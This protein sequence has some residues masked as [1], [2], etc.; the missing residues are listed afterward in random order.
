MKSKIKEKKEPKKAFKKKLA[1]KLPA[2]VQPV[3]SRVKPVTTRAKPVK[4]R[5]VIKLIKPSDLKMSVIST[6]VNDKECM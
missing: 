3:F 2:Q 6:F 5:K 4:T 1:L